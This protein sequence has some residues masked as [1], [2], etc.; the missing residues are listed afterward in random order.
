MEEIDVTVDSMEW[1]FAHGVAALQ[2]A[3]ES[4]DAAGHDEAVFY[5]KAALAGVAAARALIAG[6]GQGEEGQR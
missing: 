4:A 5:L 3:T 6:A 1:D 2:R